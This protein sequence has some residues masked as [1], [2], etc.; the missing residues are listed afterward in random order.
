MRDRRRHV[1][2]DELVLNWSLL[3]VY[4][5]DTVSPLIAPVRNDGFATKLHADKLPPLVVCMALALH[6]SDL[7]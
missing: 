7:L 4:V 1:V 2:V 3:K 5:I 6:F